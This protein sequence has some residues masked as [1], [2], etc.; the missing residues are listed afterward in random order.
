MS[1][2][3]GIW[4]PTPAR[5]FGADNAAGVFHENASHRVPALQGLSKDP[6][7]NDRA[8]SPVFSIGK[9]K[10]KR[11]KLR[12]IHHP[13]KAGYVSKFSYSL[14]RKYIRACRRIPTEI[15]PPESFRVPIRRSLPHFFSSVF[16]IAG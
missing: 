4:S 9:Q 5:P 8:A 11:G 10:R 2:R 14:Y 3:E 16:W 13:A 15:R 1:G 7:M 6:Q 12:G